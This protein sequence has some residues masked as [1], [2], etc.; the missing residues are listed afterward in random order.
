MAAPRPEDEPG[1]V[2]H[3]GGGEVSA[4]PAVVPQHPAEAPHLRPAV[5]RVSQCQCQSEDQ[6]IIVK[7]HGRL[8]VK[9]ELEVIS[10]MK[11]CQ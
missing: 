6:F 5:P 9:L 2:E 1:H 8:M 10:H 4:A 7:C 3:E 11:Q